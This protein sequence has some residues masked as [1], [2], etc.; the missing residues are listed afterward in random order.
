MKGFFSLLGSS[1]GTEREDLNSGCLSDTMRL[2][3]PQTLVCRILKKTKPATTPTKFLSRQQVLRRTKS[4]SPK[5]AN[6]T[7]SIARLKMHCCLLLAAVLA[8]ATE[9]VVSF[10]V[11]NMMKRRKAANVMPPTLSMASSSSV[12]SS[13]DIK[14]GKKKEVVT[15]DDPR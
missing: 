8:A 1:C 2:L 7:N 11:S 12:S 6:S 10:S 5:K 4:H 3:Q 13:A 9:H 15:V 14:K